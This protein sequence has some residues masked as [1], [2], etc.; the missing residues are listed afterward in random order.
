MQKNLHMMTTPTHVMW[1]RKTLQMHGFPVDKLQSAV[2]LIQW[3]ESTIPAI[4]LP[5]FALFCVPMYKL[6]LQVVPKAPGII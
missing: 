4:K 5:S 3:R 1:G 2:T 6:R